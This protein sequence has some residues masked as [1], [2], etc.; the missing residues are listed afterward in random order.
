MTY[1]SKP[2][3]A[4]DY[5]TFQAGAPTTPL[6]ANQVAADYAGHKTSIDAIIDFIQTALRSDGNLTNGIV[7]PESLSAATLALMGTEV[8]FEGTWVTATAYAVNDIVTESNKTY[9]C[10][11]AHTSGTFATDR[12]AG[13][14]QLLEGDNASLAGANVW[15]GTQEFDAAVDFD[16]AEDHSGTE[17]HSGTVNFDGPVDM[18]GT[19]DMTGSSSVTIPT[20]ATTPVAAGHNTTAASTAFVQ[21]ILAATKPVGGL[22]WSVNG[23]DA[24]NDIDV[25]AGA[26]A[27]TT[28]TFILQL[29][30]S[31]TKRLDAAWAVGTGNGGLDTGAVGNNEYY[32]W[33]I[34]RSDTGVVDFLW[35]LSATAPTM[36]TNYDF[37][38]GPCAWV[39]RSG[40]ANLAW[41][42]YESGGGAVDFRFTTPVR[43]VNLANTLT[44]TQRTDS[45]SVPKNFAVLARIRVL[46]YD[47]T[48]VQKSL[49]T[50]PG[51]TNAAPSSTDTPLSNHA[52]AN[53]SVG[54]AEEL[55]VYTSATGTIAARSDL[56]TADSYIVVTVGFYWSRR[57]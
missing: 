30:S 40:G 29:T 15:T 44:T 1:P 26:M 16:G 37:K 31:I 32:G 35:S 21:T 19:V 24:S 33:L 52:G 23:S 42:V 57:S 28:G 49:I 34:G 18:D 45:I 51:E 56:A 48:T 6:P 10:I 20:A 27:D 5:V 9:I 7:R 2:S 3:T 50:R 55:D 11:V 41:Q 43:D 17:T 47:A 39:K 25:S 38:A 54:I 13:K 4:Y 22:L 46:V 12:A 36:P 8:S 53:T 14:W